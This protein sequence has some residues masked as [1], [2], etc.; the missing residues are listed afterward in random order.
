MKVSLLLE[1]LMNEQEKKNLEK[2]ILGNVKI[3]QVQGNLKGQEEGRLETK[4]QISNYDQEANNIK[5]QRERIKNQVRQI[6]KHYEFL[7]QESI[8]DMRYSAASNR[9]FAK[10]FKTANN[11]KVRKVEEGPEDL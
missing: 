10:K 3:R 4:N 9:N 5:F 2:S 6:K 8:N 7:K 1:K 11:S